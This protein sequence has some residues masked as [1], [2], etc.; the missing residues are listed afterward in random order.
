MSTVLMLL[1]QAEPQS[2]WFTTAVACLW[3]LD[4]GKHPPAQA[5]LYKTLA[6]CFKRESLSHEL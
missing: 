4:P 5:I 2:S 6:A 1:V 3:E